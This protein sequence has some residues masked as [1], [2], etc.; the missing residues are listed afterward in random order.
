MLVLLVLISLWL[1]I[2]AGSD[3]ALFN[4]EEFI[5]IDEEQ[6][7][8]TPPIVMN[9]WT[10]SSAEIFVGINRIKSGDKCGRLIHNMI[11]NAMNP[12]RVYFGLVQEQPADDPDCISEYCRI[13]G[14]GT[15]GKCLYEGHIKSI[16]L[17]SYESKGKY[18]TRH[19]FD[20]MIGPQEFCMQ[21]DVEIE[22]NPHW[23]TELIETWTMTKNEYA[24]LSTT[25]P[26]IGDSSASSSVNH[27]CQASISADGQVVNQLPR[28]AVH[29]KRPLLA[30]LWSGDFSFSKC[31]AEL[32]TP[33]DP[34]LMYVGD[35]VSFSKFARLWTRG[36]DV[37]SLHK[38]I[39]YKHP[40]TTV[41]DVN[42]KKTYRGSP[43]LIMS[44][45]LSS[46]TRLATLLGFPEAAPSAE[47]VAQ[48]TKYGLGNKRTLDQLIDFTGIDTRKREAYENRCVDL[49]W[50]PFIPDA[51]A[52]F[53]SS[54]S[55]GLDEEVLPQGAGVPL[56]SG[57]KAIVFPSAAEAGGNATRPQLASQARQSVR[58]A[59]TAEL[60]WAF[61][62]VDMAV[63]KMVEYV[64]K[65]LEVAGLATEDSAGLVAMQAFLIV[66]PI[67]GFVYYLAILALS[68]NT[69]AHDDA[70]LI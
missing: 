2:K 42:K 68:S 18:F 56:L 14:K 34:H 38:K 57:K 41:V 21:S 45:I 4:S 17:S 20:G 55:W 5:F 43:L 69:K 1:E 16:A 66:G 27:L 60:W 24:V 3:S 61:Q 32:K 59:A 47:S 58:A 15:D 63:E 7:A 35:E 65:E 44:S 62:F 46:Y 12:E 67:I 10:P 23:D 22:V 53:D 25:L 30:P 48:L 26:L 31:H 39:L 28:E 54:D 64:D 8:Q 36:Y 40:A 49:R 13:A 51:D 11:V 70:K 50:V 33:A 29:L 6:Q 9:G 52:R 37:Y 19:L